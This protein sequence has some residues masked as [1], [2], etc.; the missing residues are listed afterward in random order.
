MASFKTLLVHNKIYQWFKLVNLCAL[1]MIFSCCLFNSYVTGQVSYDN[2]AAVI[3][4]VAQTGL[5]QGAFTV[6][7]GD[8]RIL[9]AFVTRDGSSSST[10]S[11]TFNG[12]H[13][14]FRIQQPGAGDF[15]SQLWYLKLGCGEVVTDQISG[16][17]GG[18]PPDVIISTATFQ[19]VDQNSVF[20]VSSTT[21]G[22][23]SNA[24]IS[25]NTKDENGMLIGSGSV[26]W[27]GAIG[28][29]TETAINQIEI[30][31][32]TISGNNNSAQGSTKPT[33]GG[34]DVL[35]WSLS[36]PANLAFIAYEL[37]ASDS[38]GDGVAD[39]NDLC[40]TDPLKSD[41]G[42]C[43]CREPETDTDNDE[44]PDCNDLC[45]NDILKIEPGICGCGI[46]DTDTDNDGVADCIDF[47]VIRVKDEDNNILLEVNDE[48]LVGSITLIDTSIAPEI[49]SN[50]LYGINGALYYDGT[51]LGSQDSSAGWTHTA[52]IVK[53]GI[54]NDK[55]GIGTTN[56]LS[57]LSINGNGLSNTSL[58]S[59]NLDVSGI[60]VY[61]KATNANGNS[62]GGHFESNS[63]T[64]RGVE[65]L[66]TN[67][68]GTSST[69][70]YFESKGT[71]G[72]GVLGHALSN[73]N[74]LTYG[75]FFLSNSSGGIA[76][77]GDGGAAGGLFYGN[78]AV[79][80]IGFSIGGNFE[81]LTSGSIG[82]Q[83]KGGSFDFFAD[84]PGTDYGSPSSIRWKSDIVEIGDPLKK[85]NAL[86]GVYYTWDE[87]HG[88]QHDVGMIAEEVGEVLPEIVDYEENGIDAIGMDYS[89]LT[90]LLVE[91]VKELS[92]QVEYL[93]KKNGQMELI[94]AQ[95]K[96]DVDE[97][98]SVLEQLKPK[99]RTVGSN[100]H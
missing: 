51:S 79:N 99:G 27:S 25:L 49:T 98:T 89:K 16:F 1:L 43:G 4:A 71:T 69:G 60:A 15:V 97:L 48:G 55:V 47:D 86:R 38:D 19:N 23:M 45:P 3:G 65:G 8:D 41:P 54:F 93:S 94:N 46:A 85:L 5:V 52:D 72:V 87:K 28:S 56:P 74:G 90:P 18:P 82:V 73:G 62:R 58:Y 64:G 24:S 10:D 12:Q 84:G 30:F 11:I 6:P 44:T 78:I 39:C 2:N 20:G 59:E 68:S 100:G 96:S 22:N 66:A 83:A 63:I 14:E 76:V 29:I 80:G 57:K 67:S 33:T 17:F 50:K 32:T 92:K 70:G 7:E 88:G 53:L 9:I 95:L 77:Y 91:A 34:S 36:N 31:E 61:G 40:P 37:L 81:A 35:S 75:G 21:S 26:E 42:D 13:L